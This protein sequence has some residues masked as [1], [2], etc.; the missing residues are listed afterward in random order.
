[1]ENKV[2][3]RTIMTLAFLIFVLAW[4]GVVAAKFLTDSLAV[5]TAAVTAAA[6][7][8]EGLIWVLAIIGGWAIFA[9]RRHFWKR[10]S[11]DQSSYFDGDRP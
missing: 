6:F 3:R 4:V 5:F 2:L 8:T 10:M 1:M 9:R 11:G 7:A